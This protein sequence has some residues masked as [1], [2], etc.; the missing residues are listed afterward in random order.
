MST[1]STALQALTD[2]VLYLTDYHYASADALAAQLIGI[3]SLRDVLA[4]FD[5]PG[6]PAPEQIDSNVAGYLRDLVAM[7]NDDGFWPVWSRGRPADALSTIAAV[8]GLIVAEAAGHVVSD[9]TV[10]R[11]LEALARGTDHELAAAY[12]E[13]HLP[14]AIAAKAGFID[15]IV[16]PAKTRER[17][18]A[19]FEARR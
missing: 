1:S 7:Q 17:I 19:H 15:E 2:A 9:A 3:S 13:E 14:V 16:S 18:A 6:L 5:A 8:H 4:A 11:G 12:E 10:G